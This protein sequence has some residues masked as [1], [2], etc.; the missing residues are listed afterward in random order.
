MFCTVPVTGQFCSRKLFCNTE[1]PWICLP[2]LH[3]PLWIKQIAENA[4]DLVM[5]CLYQ[6]YRHPE[7]LDSEPRLFIQPTLWCFILALAED[8]PLMFNPRT[9]WGWHCIAWG[10]I[11]SYCVVRRIYI[12]THPHGLTPSS[13]SICSSDEFSWKFLLAKT[14]TMRR[15][16]DYQRKKQANKAMLQ[17]PGWEH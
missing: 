6:S 12:G 9:C 13:H 7:S 17:L 5:S 2:W 3:V 14:W 11:S 10:P 1:T 8:D 4:V 16:R 15:W